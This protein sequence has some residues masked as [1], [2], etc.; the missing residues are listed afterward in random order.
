VVFINTEYKPRVAQFD[1][2]YNDYMASFKR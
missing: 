1:E 2:R